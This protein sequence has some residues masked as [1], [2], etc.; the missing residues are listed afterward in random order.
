MTN[1]NIM[2]TA[3]L[4]LG[5]MLCVGLGITLGYAIGAHDAKQEIRRDAVAAG[6]AEFKADANGVVSFNWKKEKGETKK[7]T[8]Q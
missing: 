1:D 5:I 2:I 8:T 3:V 4:L 7:C 6:V